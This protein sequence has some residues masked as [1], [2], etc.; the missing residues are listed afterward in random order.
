MN[1]YQKRFINFFDELWTGN[2]PEYAAASV[3]GITVSVGDATMTFGASFGAE[4]EAEEQERSF[5]AYCCNLLKKKTIMV[6]EAEASK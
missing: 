3:G 4:I 5:A 1:N 2:K 6:A